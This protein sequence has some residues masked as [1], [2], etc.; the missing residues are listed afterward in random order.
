MDEERRPWEDG[1]GRRDAVLLSSMAACRG[2]ARVRVHKEGLDR[3]LAIEGG[4]AVDPREE[5][6]EGAVDP[7]GFASARGGGLDGGEVRLLEGSHG[8]RHTIRLLLGGA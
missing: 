6:S 5:K 7:L 2:P 1:S 3:G 4:G 8:A